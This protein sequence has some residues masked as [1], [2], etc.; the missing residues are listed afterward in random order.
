MRESSLYNTLRLEAVKYGCILFRNNSGC[1]QD[2]RGEYVRYGVASPGGAD[3][4]GWTRRHG[5]AVFTAVEVKV[6][7]RKATAAQQAFLA[8]VL[9]AGGIAGVV[10]SVEDLRALL[11]E[12]LP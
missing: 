3:L 4:I 10:R 8:A 5:V 12:R 7:I 11:E 1:L 6:G 9:A 2:Q